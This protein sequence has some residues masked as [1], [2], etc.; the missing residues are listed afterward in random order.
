MEALQDKRVRLQPECKKRLQD[1]IDM[2]SYAAKVWINT[3]THRHTLQIFCLCMNLIL[4][5][6]TRWRQRKAFQTWPCRWWPR[7]RRTTS[8]WWSQWACACSSWWDCYV[9]ASPSGSHRNWRTGRGGPDHLH[10]TLSPKAH[11][12][13]PKPLSNTLGLAQMPLPNPQG[14]CSH[15]GSYSLAA[16]APYQL[17][18]SASAMF[19]PPHSHSHIVLKNKYSNALAF[20]LK[21]LRLRSFFRPVERGSFFLFEEILLFDRLIPRQTF[22]GPFSSWLET[23]RLSFSQI[24]Y[25]ML[26]SILLVRTDGSSC[27]SSVTRP[28]PTWPP[29]QLT[30]SFLL[31]FVPTEKN[32]LLICEVGVGFKF[33]FVFV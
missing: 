31:L 2:W 1:R 15:W 26:I 10:K 28:A 7:L 20:L 4:S 19:E 21:L 5:L 3:H 25:C 17:P 23:H 18:R 27:I 13:C 32:L 29:A 30:Q 16:Q 11:L 14:S 33:F 8:C 9:D 12:R 22:C 6:S 24:W